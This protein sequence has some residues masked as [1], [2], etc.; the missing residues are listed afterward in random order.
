MVKQMGPA[1]F[2]D[3]STFLTGSECFRVSKG[4]FVFLD[5]GDVNN[6]S[7]STTIKEGRGTDFLL[8]SFSNEKYSKHDK[9]SSNISYSF[10]RYRLGVQVSYMTVRQ[11]DQLE[12]LIFVIRVRMEHFKVMWNTMGCSLRVAW[13]VVSSST[14]VAL[15]H[16]GLEPDPLFLHWGL[17]GHLSC[18]CPDLLQ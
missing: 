9:R 3:P 18:Q 1:L 17:T 8:R 14:S 15:V 2:E 13:V 11:Q 6:H 5:K 10:F 16:S 12:I 4:K 7:F